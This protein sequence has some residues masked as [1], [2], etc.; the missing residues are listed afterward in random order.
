VTAGQIAREIL[1]GFYVAAAV[2]AAAMVAG[3]RT[4]RPLVV[5]AA[6]LL[7][8]LVVIFEEWG[9]EP[10][11]AA[12]AR[13]ARY[14]PIAALERWIAGLPPLGALFIFAAPMT[15]LF[16]LKLVAVWLL[17]QGKVLMAGALFVGAKLASTAIVARLFMLTKPALMRIGWFA[18]A[19]TWYLPWQEAAFAWLRGSWAWRQGRVVKATVKRAL[20]PLKRRLL[21]R[22]SEVRDA[23]R[24]RWP[25]IVRRSRLV[26]VT[27]KREA[28]ALAARLFGQRML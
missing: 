11:A 15:L 20:M 12:L 8:A 25:D 18:R 2:A 23:I 22:A 1:K 3:W 26:L 19:Y 24:A 17:A 7:L 21:A 5:A 6:Q 9:W 14:R 10:L 27:W 28:V 16:P 13:L 4:L